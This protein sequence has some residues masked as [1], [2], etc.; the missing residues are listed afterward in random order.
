[1]H[2]TPDGGAKCL[3]SDFKINSFLDLQKKL[4]VTKSS[5]D[6]CPIHN[7]PL[8]IY[9]ETCREVIC[10]DCTFS[11]VHKTHKHH[12]ISEC[13]L[14]HHQEIENNLD[15]VKDKMADISTMLTHLDARERKVIEEGEE[16]QKEIA[17]HAKMIKCINHMHA[18]QNRYK[19]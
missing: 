5:L 16:L 9:C 3:P 8:K 12:L 1:M 6:T 14:K 2:L 7:D 19:Q 15:V 17:M 10:R 13:Y 11:V 4:T 18:Y